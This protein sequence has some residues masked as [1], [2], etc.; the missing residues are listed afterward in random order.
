MVATRVVLGV[1]TLISVVA[2]QCGE[3]TSKVDCGY[4]GID[5]NGCE[6]KG[7][8]W[9]PVDPNPNNDP[10]CYTAGVAPSPSPTPSPTP[11]PSP[12]TSDAKNPKAGQDAFV[13]LFEWSWSDVALECEQFLGPK[14]F[15]AV[16]ISPPNEHI[17][18]DAWWTRYQPVTYE[19]VSRS[20][21]ANAFADMVK[22]CNAAGVG[23]YAD[24]VINHIAAGSGTSI[25]GKSYGNRATPIYSANDM[26]HNDG[27]TGSNCQVS[28]YSN[29]YN[30]Q[31]CD[32]VG[33]PDLCTSCD[34]VQKTV[35]GYLNDMS[36]IGIAGFRV[37]AAKHQDAGELGQLLSRADNSLFRFHE[38][39]SGN[40]EAVTPQ[41]YTSIGEVTEFSYFRQLAPNF[42]DEGKLQYLENFGESWGLIASSSA[43]VF[44]DNHDTQRGEAPLTYKNGNLYELANIF[45]LAHP[46][47]YPKI[48]SSYYFD[49]HDQGPP[50]SSVHNGGNV[51][52]GNGNP[53]V[54][55]HR[56]TGV[57]NMVAWRKSAG[58]SSVE[59]FQKPSGNTVAFCRGGA[60]CVALN[61]GGGEWSAS[62]TFSVPAGSY[63]NVIVSD[64][65]SSC[66]KVVVKSDGSAS[67]QVPATGAVAVH[68]GKK[69]ADATVL[70]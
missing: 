61:R 36:D 20:G 16:Q 28:D 32:L 52:C 22:R 68:V 53:W 60:A 46:Y 48:M 39:I 49:N 29:K 44:M 8:C 12:T 3:V 6:S 42:L 35:S 23:I 65:V 14:G 31:H 69:T 9:V 4:A 37:D 7:C 27:N 38:V 26:H 57:A 59:K 33:L 1:T 67:F 13:H 18:G 54:C 47:G 19:L 63:C 64:D 41:M 43:V 62:V 17:S 10:W 2:D 50:S 45:M 25:A 15:T 55:E 51:A 11:S 5:Q 24:A 21:D 58:T 40:N 66:P 70:V 56:W 34:Y 30:V